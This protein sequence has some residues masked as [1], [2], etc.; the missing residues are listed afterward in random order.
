M[1][2]G[3]LFLLSALFFS[4]VPFMI[5]QA[6]LSNSQISDLD[7]IVVA[8]FSLICIIPFGLFVKGLKGLAS[9]Q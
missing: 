3:L 6:L 1:G 9:T 7:I 5:I 4:L 8:V 2:M